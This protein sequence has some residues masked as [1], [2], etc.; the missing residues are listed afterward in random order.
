MQDITKHIMPNITVLNLNIPSQWTMTTTYHNTPLIQALLVDGP[1]F[2]TRTATV[3]DPEVWHSS[4]PWRDS[5]P[6]TVLQESQKKS[7]Y[8]TQDCKI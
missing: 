2:K 6:F 4:K 5:F 1:Q 8:I 7:N 3:G